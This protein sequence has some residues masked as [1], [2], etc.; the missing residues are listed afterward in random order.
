MALVSG[1]L[2]STSVGLVPFAEPQLDLSLPDIARALAASPR[3]AGLPPASLVV[4]KPPHPALAVLG[5]FTDEELARVSAIRSVFD[6][7]LPRLQYVSYAGAEQACERLAE[8]LIERLGRDQMTRLRFV[9]IPRGGLF[10]LGMLSY[11]LDLD[12]SQIESGPPVGSDAVVVVDDCAYSG[13]RFS[14]F[15]RRLDGP[16]VVFAHLY[17]HPGLRAAIEAAEPRVVACVSAADLH[18]AAPQELGDGYTAWKARAVAAA[19]RAAYWTGRPDHVCFAW[20]EPDYS[21]WNSTTEALEKGW[22]VM[23]PDRS[24]KNRPALG[25]P[26]IPVQEQPEGRGVLRPGPRVLFGRVDGHVAVGDLG[27]GTTLALE[28]TAAEMWEAIVA[29]RSLDEARQRLL[30]TFDVDPETLR[31]DLDRFARDLVAGGLLTEH[32]GH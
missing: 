10:V 12:Q 16:P 26:L 4:R 1:E 11:L 21:T 25:R 23:P 13:S 7:V 3:W 8:R 2:D 5:S 9:G 29:S 18:D 32:P 19:D 22:P 27:T 24:L 28:G 31:A 17:S 20:G 6:A 15:L 30:A 14:R